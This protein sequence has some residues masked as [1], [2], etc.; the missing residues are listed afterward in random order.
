MIIF[1]VEEMVLWIAAGSSGS[2][3]SQQVADSGRRAAMQSA[4][5]HRA[6]QAPT[7][8][9]PARRATPCRGEF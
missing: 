3:G 6:N 1:R 8:P 7:R 2:G 5:I 4:R 9:R